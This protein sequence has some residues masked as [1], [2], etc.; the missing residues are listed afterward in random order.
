MSTCTFRKTRIV[1]Y[2]ND[3]N[4]LTLSNAKDKITSNKP[5]VDDTS[6]G[7]A[8]ARIKAV[9]HNWFR[10][11]TN[12]WGLYCKENEWISLMYNNKMIIPKHMKVS[13]GHTIPTAR[14]PSG[15]GTTTSLSFNNTIFSL[16]YENHDTMNVISDHEFPNDDDFI[17]FHRTYDGAKASDNTRNLLPKADLLYKFP[18]YRKTADNNDTY[19]KIGT[20][21]FGATTAPTTQISDEAADMDV[22]D[23]K[24]AYMPEFLLD[25]SNVSVLYPG[26]N[27]YIY[28]YTIPDNDANKIDFSAGQFNESFASR[29]LRGQCR[30]NSNM[31]N[32]S[33][34]TN[35]MLKGYVVPRVRNSNLT[36]NTKPDAI[37]RTKDDLYFKQSFGFLQ[38]GPHEV[39]LKGC[40]VLD[41]SNNLVSHSFL[42]TVT[43]E[44]TLEL[45]HNDIWIPR[46]LIE[47]WT[48]MAPYCY[49]NLANVTQRKARFYKPYPR[50]LQPQGFMR[51]PHAAP[52]FTDQTE[53]SEF[54]N[55]SYAFTNIE[56]DVINF[57]RFDTANDAVKIVPC[58]E[59]SKRTAAA[60][61]TQSTSENL[62]RKQIK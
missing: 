26:E 32:N 1:Y 20:Q 49:N 60:A 22:D 17:S 38:D 58:D 23:L 6:Y 29:D 41:P 4:K 44:L 46:P 3:I 10:L 61:A 12:N 37:T 35:R 50:K 34:M 31:N 24:L 54:P 9:D 51:T 2:E 55:Q 16:I 47:G 36:R 59:F 42:C 14:Y 43:W 39:W 15:S 8:V 57:Q 52:K 45:I 33:G 48:M 53:D 25:D 27:Q 30:I 19:I 21:A 7:Y 18:D 40:P 56:T 62:I 5:H 13:L 11:P 28:E